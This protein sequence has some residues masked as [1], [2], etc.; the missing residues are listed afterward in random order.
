MFQDG[1]KRRHLKGS[2]KAKMATRYRGN[3]INFSFFLVLI[4]LM[5]FKEM[6]KEIL[7]KKFLI[8]KKLNFELCT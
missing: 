3:K 8:P 4:Y 5:V 1:N 7:S 6:I 2:E